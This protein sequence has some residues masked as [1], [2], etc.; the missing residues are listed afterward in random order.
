MRRFVT[1]TAV[2]SYDLGLLIVPMAF[3]SGVF[4]GD[5]MACTMKTKLL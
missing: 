3:M 2:I 5:L 4:M 1:E